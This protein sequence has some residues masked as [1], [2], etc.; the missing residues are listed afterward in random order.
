MSGEATVDT[1]V[2]AHVKS[3]IDATCE[4]HRIF[5]QDRVRLLSN[6]EVVND[7]EV[8]ISELRMVRWSIVSTEDRVIELW[9]KVM[10]GVATTDGDVMESEDATNQNIVDYV[11]NGVTFV[12]LKT[13][14]SADVRDKVIT[15]VAGSIAWTSTSNAIDSALKDR[16]A[17]FD[18]VFKVFS[19]TPWLL[20]M[21]LLSMSPISFNGGFSSP[22]G[23]S[24]T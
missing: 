7:L 11:L 8:F 4:W 5:T 6:P 18:F 21:F 20:F 3:L 13:P 12:M 10:P 16:A 2:N 1:V 15:E 24:S 14:M 19:T 9:N 22:A 17:E 23:N